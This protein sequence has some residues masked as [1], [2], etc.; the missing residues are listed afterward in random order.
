MKTKG[1]IL[2]ILLGFLFMGLFTSCGKSGGYGSGYN[3]NTPPPASA[4]SVSISNMTFSPSS[5]TVTVGTTVT[6]TNNDGMDHTV[7]SATGIFDSGNLAAGGK[8]THNFGTVGSFPYK[9]TI[10]AGM[11]GTIVVKAY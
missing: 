1:Y 11:A 7:T 5:L 2:S 8:F 6:W 10:H 9:C 4:N 3:N